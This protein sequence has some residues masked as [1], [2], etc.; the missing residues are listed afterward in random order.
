MNQEAEAL[1]VPEHENSAKVVWQLAWPAVALNSLQVVNTLLDNF[2]VGHLPEFSLVAYGGVTNIV[3][4]LFSVSF[5]VGTAATA[6][7]SRAFGAGNRPELQEACRQSV[8]FSLVVGCLLAAI[9]ALTA[10]LAASTFLPA[11]EVDAQRAMTQY[12]PIYATGLPAIIL[13]QA[14]A[15]SLRGVG[16][17]RSPMVVSGI[18]IL[19]HILLNFFLISGPR[20][21]SFGFTMPGLGWGLNG[22]GVSITLSAWISALGYLLVVPRTKLGVKI[23]P[24]WVHRDWFKRIL[25][26][27]APAAMM[28]VLRVASLAA[29]TIALKMSVD[30]ASAIAAMRPGFAIESMMFMP[31][32][33]LSMAAGA[34]VGQSLGMGRPDRAERL[35]WTAANHGALMSVLVSIPVFAFAPQIAHLLVGDKEQIASQTI[36]LLRWLCATEFA[37]NYAMIMIGAMQGAGDTKSPLWITIGA[38]WCL[39][40]P[41]T[42]LLVLRFDLTLAG[43]LFAVGAGM[44]PVGA[45]IAMSAS[46]F[47]QGVLAVIAFQRGRWKL[48][49]V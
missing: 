17:T 1:A 42:F 28:A 36:L 15:G 8:N 18:Q 14:L 45:W 2:F 44:G 25:R 23:K 3:F 7:V 12:L 26:I 32:F 39:R 20:E 34:L 10:P 49:K 37:F 41:M 9:G 46:Q 35:A 21:T 24:G 27:A 6:L 48:Q 13:I 16:D 33:G 40:V 30:G 43:S 11:T 47:A 22:A 4:L 38:L 31:A 19:L 29:F 5:S